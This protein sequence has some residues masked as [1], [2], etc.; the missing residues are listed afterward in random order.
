MA[1]MRKNG[2]SSD[3]SK[4]PRLFLDFQNL[5]LSDS[6]QSW[7]SCSWESFFCGAGAAAETV[8]LDL[9]RQQPSRL[10]RAG[11]VQARCFALAAPA[12][13]TGPA[14]RILVPQIRGRPAEA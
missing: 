1:A 14:Q 11:L 3:C 6:P 2:A 9:R 8:S 4:H 12:P 10:A 5:P 7:N 13:V